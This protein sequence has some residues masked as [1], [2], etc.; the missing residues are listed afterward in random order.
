MDDTRVSSVGLNHVLNQ[1][2]YILFYVRR[3][4]SSQT[5]GALK[6]SS[7]LFP[8]PSTTSTPKQSTSLPNKSLTQRPNNGPRLI[9]ESHIPATIPAVKIVSSSATVTNGQL[10][11]LS[12]KVE[13]SP[14]IPRPE[15]SFKPP[16]ME[17]KKPG[18]VKNLVPYDESDSS[19]DEGGQ[20]VNGKAIYGVGHILSQ[21]KEILKTP[22]LQHPTSKSL[23][24]D[25]PS[26]KN[27]TATSSLPSPF[28]IGQSHGLSSLGANVK[29]WEGQ[30][31]HVD[32]ITKQE[33]CDE[34]NSDDE[35]D[36]GRVKKVKHHHDKPNEGSEGNPFDK[37]QEYQSRGESY[38][39]GKHFPPFGKDKWFGKNS[40]W[41]HRGG[42]HNY[43]HGGR[44]N[45]HK[46]P[47]WK[48]NHHY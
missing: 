48:K 8:T 12:K 45:F 32:E 4:L 14:P 9:S 27:Q 20:E 34:K 33:D 3:P 46:K 40:Q 5:N 13:P 28:E 31:N 29:S 36:I 44:G 42:H 24:H 35:L 37:Y 16:Q 17:E 38:P 30:S 22:Q 43:H 10:L 6:R 1:N 18:V 41:K 47:W 2:A 23:S 25:Q 21:A 7:E 15:T 19:S 39:T 26:N 11:S